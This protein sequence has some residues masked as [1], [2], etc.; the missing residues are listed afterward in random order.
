MRAAKFDVDEQWKAIRNTVQRT[1]HY[2]AHNIKAYTT[3]KA[4]PNTE[5]T[6]MVYNNKVR[7]YIKLA[8]E[9]K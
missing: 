5:N 9:N 1:W 8:Y 2:T 7:K 4:V 6:E 3:D